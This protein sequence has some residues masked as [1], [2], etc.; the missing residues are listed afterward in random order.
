MDLSAIVT[1]AIATLTTQVNAAFTTLVPFILLVAVG[2]AAWRY[3]KR[4]LGK[5]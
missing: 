1:S 3:T 2:F 5:V 4:I